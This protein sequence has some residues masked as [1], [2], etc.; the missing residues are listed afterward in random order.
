MKLLKPERKLELVELGLQLGQN[1][2]NRLDKIEVYTKSKPFVSNQ[3][4]SVLANSKP[5]IL[6][7]KATTQNDRDDTPHTSPKFKQ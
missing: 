7:L 3:P 5:P 6:P 1:S 2:I 4:S